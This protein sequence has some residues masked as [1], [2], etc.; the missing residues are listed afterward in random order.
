MEI[1]G[2]LIHK[3]SRESG[4][5]NSGKD[6]QKQTIV[7]EEI[8]GQY[9]KKIAI[10]FFGDKVDLIADL[11]KDEVLTVAVNIESREYNKRWFTNVGG[12]KLETKE[13]EAEQ[14]PEAEVATDDL[15]F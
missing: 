10:D 15:P 12:W 14:T 7:I 3:L 2:K 13:A 4:T 6:W 11:K 1:T 5:A 9:P 8:A